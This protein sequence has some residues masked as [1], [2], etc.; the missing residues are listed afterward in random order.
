M[1]TKDLGCTVTKE[2]VEAGRD[3][4]SLLVEATVAKCMN[5]FGG[6]QTYAEW[7]EVEVKNKDLAVAYLNDEICSVEAIYIAMRRAA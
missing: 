6:S 3:L 1:K 7:F 5:G 2:M 4:A